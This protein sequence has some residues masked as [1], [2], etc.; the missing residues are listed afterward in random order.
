MVLTV[1]LA[2]VVSIATLWPKNGRTVA[3][4]MPPGQGF[5]QAAA[6]VSA[7]GGAIKAVGG[8]GGVVITDLTGLDGADRLLENGAWLVIDAAAAKGCFGL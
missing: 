3:A 6:V 2:L 1:S 7:A 4:I 8:W 5:D